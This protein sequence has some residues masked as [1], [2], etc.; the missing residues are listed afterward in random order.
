MKSIKADVA[1]NALFSRLKEAIVR[2]LMA[3]PV[4]N[5]P[6]ENP[7]NEPPIIAFL[8]VGDI[9]SFLLIRNNRLNPTKNIPRKNSKKR[10]FNIL[11]RNPPTT[12]KTT[13]G[14]PIVSNNLW[15]RLF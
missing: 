8:L 14:I 13:D 15:S 7:E 4:P 9:V 3:P 5:N 12:T 11:D 10:L 6:A 1:I 2:P